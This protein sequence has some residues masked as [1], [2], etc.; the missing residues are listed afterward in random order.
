MRFEG[1]GEECKERHAF[2]CR[3]ECLHNRI[4]L[5]VYILYIQSMFLEL[6]SAFGTIAVSAKHLAVVFGCQSA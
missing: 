4:I 1:K 2:M 5:I 6:F 3:S